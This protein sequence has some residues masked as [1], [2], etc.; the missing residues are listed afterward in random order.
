MKLVQLSC[1]VEIIALLANG[2]VVYRLCV[3]NQTCE[4]MQKMKMETIG[5]GFKDNKKYIYFVLR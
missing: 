5:K 1:F 2:E 3:D 4:N